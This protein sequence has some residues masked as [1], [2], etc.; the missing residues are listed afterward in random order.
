MIGREEEQEIERFNSLPKTDFGKKI[1][2]GR[3]VQFQSS[4]R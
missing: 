2:P 3:G 4:S 1:S